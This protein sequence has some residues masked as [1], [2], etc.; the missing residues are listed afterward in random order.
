MERNCYCK[1]GDQYCGDC[2]ICGK[3]GHTRHAP[4]APA[5]LGYCDECYKKESSESFANFSVTK[6]NAENLSCILL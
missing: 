2:H 5:I 1:P 6:Q 4:N 3:G